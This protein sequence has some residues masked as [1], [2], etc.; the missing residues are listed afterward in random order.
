MPKSQM[1][2]H[3][4]LL[5]LTLVPISSGPVFAQTH[6]AFAFPQTGSWQQ[7][8]ELFSTQAEEFS[9]VG[10]AV[11]IDGDTAVVGGPGYI[12]DSGNSAPGA[13]YVYA[14][15]ASGW[16][17]MNQLAALTTSDGGDAPGYDFGVAVAILGDTIF[18]GSQY[19]GKVYIYQKPA[20]GWT[21]MTESATLSD[22][23]NGSDGFGS[24]LAINGRTLVVGACETK[25]A[26]GLA[27]IFEEPATGWKTT[28]HPNATL[29]ASDGTS[30]DLF[31]SAVAI[32]G[33]T[34]AVGAPT[35]PFAFLY[36]AAYVFTKPAAGWRTTTETA[37]L[38]AAQ[39][40]QG[41]LLGDSVLIGENTIFT[42]APGASLLPTPG[43]VSV[44]VE[45]AGGW[46]GA[47]Q[48]ALL[49]DGTGSLDGVG[50]T[51]GMSGNTLLAGAPYASVN[52]TAQGEIYLFQKPQSGWHSTSQP[53]GSFTE[54]NG[55]NNDEFA[56]S[57]AVQNSTA[58]AG[59]PDAEKAIIFLLK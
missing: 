55:E 21:N 12:D 41:A 13:A 38:V 52:G 27:Y 50:L 43:S 36:G 45:P 26:Q 1:W 40:V 44:F 47:K 42:G 58:L 3:R 46:R 11:A 59:V 29:A 14:K 18:V 54:L 9:F 8:A 28:T 5:L 19:A 56:Y 24:A 30:D 37:K 33:N 32:A 6:S 34:I 17:N 39:P 51:L 22:G 7:V 48:T 16:A 23:Q 2:R 35:K 57:L 31:G 25:A 20:G 10:A 15:P 53:I 49:T 4:I